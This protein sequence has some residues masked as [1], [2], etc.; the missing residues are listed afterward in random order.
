MTAISE[1]LMVQVSQYLAKNL[2][3]H[4]PRE[5]WRDLERG[6][7]EIARNR[8]FET[9]E[10]CID[11]LLSTGAE[12]ERIEALAVQFTVGETYFHREIQ[13]IQALEQHVLP[14]LI[15][16][17]QGGEQRLHI[18]SAGCCTGEEPYSIAIL[19][20]RMIPDLDR[21]NINILGTDINACFL[22]KARAGIYSQWSFRGAPHGIKDS[23]FSKGQD[24]RLEILPR[25]K[26]M[27]R[28]EQLNLAEETSPLFLKEISGMDLILCRNVL[29]YFSP[30]TAA[31][32]L[33]TFHRSLSPGGWLVVSQ[34]ETS[35]LDSSCFAT[36]NFPGAVLFKKLENKQQRPAR[37]FGGH[38]FQPELEREISNQHESA[39]QYRWFEPELSLYSDTEP[40]GEPILDALSLRTRLPLTLEE[41]LLLSM[42]GR[43]QELENQSLDLCSN[44][45]S[46]TD[47]RAMSSLAKDLANQG[48][49][50]EAFEWVER[51]IAADK[52]DACSRY[53]QATILQEQSRLDDAITSL[54]R[55]IYLEPDFVI[56]HFSLGNLLL[57]QGRS[58]EGKRSMATALALLTACAK[59]DPL[60]ESDGMSAARL[61]EIITSIMSKEAA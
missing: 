52:L 3:W 53:L 59:D 31:S 15:R 42:Q 57:K 17:R 16:S 50:D 19:L 14:E 18:W 11:W 56:A 51:A 29:I 1:A 9:V 7:T 40:K 41:E 61:T 27:V 46:V 44:R 25:I 48:K 54:I 23:Y 47:P 26:R 5:R 10:A 43:Y 34:T 33:Q 45:D 35:L 21:W 36:M 30:E 2:G 6:L 55:A 12:K 58:Q 8:H 60:P 4:F 37:I 24:H 13:S 28:L 49:Y 39:E 22:E 20:D 38:S 32:V